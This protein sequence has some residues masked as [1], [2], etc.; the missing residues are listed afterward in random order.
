M[1]A[2]SGLS[3][4]DAEHRRRRQ[5]DDARIDAEQPRRRGVRRCGCGRPRRPRPRRWQSGRGSSRRSGAAPRR[6]GACVSSST[7]ERSSRR[8]LAASSPAMRLNA[9]MSE[10]NS[11][12]R[13]RLDAVIEVA[14]A[15]L[16]GGRRQHLHRPR[17]PL[18]QVQPHPGRA[19]ENHQRQHQEEREV[20]AG[21]RLPAARAAAGSPR[22]PAVM[23]R[24]ARRELAGEV[25][26]G[27]DDARA[28]ARSATTGSAPRVRISSPPLGS[29]S[30]TRRLGAADRGPL[31]EAVGRRPRVLARQ[32]RRGDVDDRHRPADAAGAGARRGR[33][34]RARRAPAARR[35]ST[36]SRTAPASAARQV[37]RAP[38]SRAS[39]CA[40]ADTSRC[41]SW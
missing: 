26:A 15:D 21:Q 16:V 1:S 3:S 23:P 20:D 19:H 27:D 18:G 32:R 37:D 22:R 4:G 38:A 13:L 11:S 34:R 12:R 36:T 14:G 25:L 29:C 7:A 40:C 6:P 33:P 28:P 41:R 31:G 39:R 2:A 24:G 8:R 17:D 35:A 30:T 5:P 9:S 10:P